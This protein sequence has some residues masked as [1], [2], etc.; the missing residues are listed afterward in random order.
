MLS[1][2]QEK[3][4][5]VTSPTS[6]LLISEAVRCYEASA[7]RA[8]IVTAWIA[9][10]SDLI[11]KMRELSLGGEVQA[12]NEIEKLEKHQQSV[13][14]NRKSSIKGLLDFERNLIDLFYNEFQFFGFQEF[15]DIDRLREDRHRCAHPSYDIQD[16]IYLPNAE[17]ARLHLVNAIDLVLS[18]SPS[19]G[20]AALGRL[21]QLV[22]SKNFP[23]DLAL[24][25]ERMKSSEFGRARES[26]VRAFTDL[27]FFGFL[28]GEPDIKHNAH[29]LLSL[30]AAIE[31]YRP[32]VIERI[33][34]QLNKIIPRMDDDSLFACAG[35]LFMIPET[36]ELV[37]LPNR[38]TLNKWVLNETG[39]AAGQSIAFSYSV[40]WLRDSAT[41]R[42][43]TLTLDEIYEN[44]DFVPPILD[45]AVTLV[46]EVKNW[47]QA[48]EVIAKVLLQNVGM[49]EQR[50]IEKIY[51]AAASG[52]ADLQGSHGFRQIIDKIYELEPIP[53]EENSRLLEESGLEFYKREL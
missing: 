11:E 27:T 35:F 24:A 7:Y 28:D 9:V 32:I 46:C 37:D 41:Q 19:S 6:R 39:P 26:L 20:K 42:A 8:A 40:P 49:L 14:Q 13:Q 16:D 17:L 52:Q 12:T 21:R 4:L 15:L 36:A 43:R 22:V 25:V 51:N 1:N 33:Q 5:T 50:H 38:G 30:S 18:K 44:T 23:D 29:A 34:I 48:N 31:M 45:R 2:L 47:E 53:R 3:L 10:S